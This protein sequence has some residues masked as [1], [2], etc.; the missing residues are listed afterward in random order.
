MLG[1]K[2]L[3]MLALILLTISPNAQAASDDWELDYRVPVTLLVNAKNSD[4]KIEHRIYYVNHPQQPFL[5]FACDGAM[6]DG[7]FGLVVNNSFHA[8]DYPAAISEALLWWKQ[9]GML[10]CGAFNF[11]VLVTNYPKYL[12]KEKQLPILDIKLVTLNSDK[13]TLNLITENADSNG[14]PTEL[15]VY[16]KKF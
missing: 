5:I 3:A 10:N 9:K 16:H 13:T 4:G 6:K 8:D 2:I 7:R 11:V 12:A 15:L 14:N 1:K